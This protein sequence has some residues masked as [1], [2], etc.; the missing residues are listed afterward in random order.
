MRV[1]PVLRGVCS[2]V[3]SGESIDRSGV[4]RIRIILWSVKLRVLNPKLQK[5]PLI[6]EIKKKR[7]VT[8]K[9][10]K[11]HRECLLLLA[12]K[13]SFRHPRRY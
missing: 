11:H 12:R 8:D 3:K 9:A 2:F 7:H 6:R 1:I 10:R 4:Q 13:W 5:Q